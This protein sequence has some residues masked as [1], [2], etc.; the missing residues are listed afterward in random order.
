MKYTDL[1]ET[2]KPESINSGLE[3]CPINYIIRKYGAPSKFK[4]VNCNNSKLSPFWKLRMG[5][6][7]VGPFKVY[8]FKPFLYMLKKA[9]VEVKQTYPDLYNELTTAGCLCVRKV[10]GGNSWSNHSLGMAIDIKIGGKLDSF[11]DNKTQY[12]LLLL[13]SILKKYD[14][15]WGAE[16]ANRNREDSMHFEASNKMV[17]YWEKEGYLTK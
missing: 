8:G 9:L 1:I 11:G 2:P 13:Y 15:Y 4:T 5:T 6:V 14:F 16:W 10:R 3:S 7:D 12:G 17:S